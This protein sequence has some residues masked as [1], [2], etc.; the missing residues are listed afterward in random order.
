MGESLSRIMVIK[1]CSVKSMV[2]E[3]TGMDEAGVGLHSVY[4]LRCRILLELTRDRNHDAPHVLT[5]VHRHRV[6]W[7]SQIPCD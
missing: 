2:L 6:T 7:P 3:G 5:P 4:G 1:I